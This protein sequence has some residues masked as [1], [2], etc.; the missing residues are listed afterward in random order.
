MC[1]FNFLRLFATCQRNDKAV[2]HGN[3]KIAR[4]RATNVT[5]LIVKNRNTEDILDKTNETYCNHLIE[6]NN[7]F[8]VT[9]GP[10]VT[11]IN[12]EENTKTLKTIEICLVVKIN[13]MK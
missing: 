8:A 11:F 10:Y 4:H 1:M 9:D 5:F 3:I 13:K 7:R 2:P 6:S 12:A